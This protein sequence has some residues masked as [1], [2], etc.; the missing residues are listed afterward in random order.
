MTCLSMGIKLRAFFSFTIFVVSLFIHISAFAEAALV[1]LGSFWPNSPDGGGVALGLSDD[2]TIAT[3]RS[4]KQSTQDDVAFRWDKATLIEDLGYLPGQIPAHNISAGQVISGDG[5]TIFGWSESDSERLRITW[6]KASGMQLLDIGNN[7]VKAASYDGSVQVGQTNGALGEAFRRSGG[8]ITQ[9]GSL[10]TNLSRL[11]S[12]AAAVSSDGSVVVGWSNSDVGAAIR[13]EAF[14]WT[15]PGGM[16]GLGFL[17]SEGFVESEATAV[18]SSGDIVAGNARVFEDG[19]SVSHGFIWQQGSGMQSFYASPNSG[20]LVVVTDISADGKVIVGSLRTLE[21]GLEQAFRY[22]EA[23][24][25]QTVEQWLTDA[26]VDLQ[27]WSIRGVS[28]VSADGKTLA[29]YIE[30]ATWYQPY[31]AYVI[32]D[33]IYVDGFE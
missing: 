4:V 33:D 12:S 3:G 21:N 1:P 24:G 2:G 32:S 25:F 16:V 30:N 26:G 7:I 10:T 15:E 9:I 31:I 28:A 6:T 22:S 11:K 17:P 5:L 14:R 8:V 13:K 20:V 23:G 19:K 27:G 29:G 18:S